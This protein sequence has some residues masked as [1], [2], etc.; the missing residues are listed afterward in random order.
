MVKNL[1]ELADVTKFLT[2][3]SE[4]DIIEYQQSLK[5]V[6]NRAST[7]LQ[8]NVYQ[9]RTQFIKISKEAEKLKGEMQTLRGLMSELTTT[10]AQT[11]VSSS[12]GRRSPSFD[13]GSSS[14]R[15]RAN[16]SSVANLEAMWTT[17]LQVL[18][19][20]IEGS[21]KFLPAIP[22]RH[23]VQESGYWVELDAATWKP[24]R[25]VHMVLLNDHLLI[26][27]R[28][29]KRV[30]PSMAA[31]QKAPTKLVAERCWPLYDIDLVDLAL[32]AK[33]IKGPFRETKDI[34]NAITV[35]QGQESFTYYSDRADAKEKTDLLLAF[36][37]TVDEL[38]RAERA[39]V[40]E[41]GKTKDTLNYAHPRNPSI[42]RGPNLME[43]LGRSRDRPDI[44]IDVDGKQRSLRWVESQIDELDI[45]IALQRFEEAVTRVEQLRRLAKGLKNNIVA[46]NFV[47]AKV[48]ER[49]SKLAG[50]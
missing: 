31:T 29:R 30:D 14:A 45:E 36:K 41:M 3:A 25:P 34:S 12:T 43:P 38:R 26:A 27:T 8:H 6:K 4:Q 13:E 35:R 24:R 20:N 21:Q 28:K 18:W 46:Q 23:V 17:Q 1:T 48:D 47:V 10:L 44:L 5:K 42:S 49:V 7:D 19:K 11:S 33:E 2:N 50:S 39:E 32:G 22:G 40:D 15:K 9:N 37:R 16:R